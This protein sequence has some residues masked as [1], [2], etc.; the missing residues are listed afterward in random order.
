MLHIGLTRIYKIKK[1]TLAKRAT[2]NILE[3][4]DIIKITY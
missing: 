3:Q 4:V 1:V 2:L